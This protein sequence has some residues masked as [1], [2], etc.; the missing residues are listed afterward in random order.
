M[1]MLVT[2]PTWAKRTLT[3][4]G[5]SAATLAYSYL[6]G[7]GQSNQLVTVTNSGSSYRSYGYDPNGNATSD[8]MGRTIQYNLLN[9][10]Q[11]V[12]Q[13]NNSATTLATYTY[14]AAGTKIRNTGSDGYWDYIN[15]IVYN[16]TTAMNGAIQFIQ[17]E[18][19]RVLNQ[20]GTW[21]YEYNLKDHLGNI[22]LSFDRDPSAGTVR[23]IRTD[24]W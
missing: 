19:G 21:H 22:R 9:M 23:R 24:F 20:S 12:S 7:P 14:D 2:T 3:R 11:N 5:V 16:G 10:P 13:Q 8:G 17:T 15:W 6:N 4:V 18:E 1:V